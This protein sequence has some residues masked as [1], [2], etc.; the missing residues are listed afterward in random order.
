[1]AKEEKLDE[2]IHR[3]KKL[4]ECDKVMKKEDFQE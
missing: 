2:L 4:D 1:V 3:V